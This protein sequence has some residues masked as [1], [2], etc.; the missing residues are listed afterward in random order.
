MADP[1]REIIEL[2]ELRKKIHAIMREDAVVHHY[3]A[4]IHGVRGYRVICATDEETRR[5]FKIPSGQPAADVVVEVS[6]QRAIVAEVKGS[7]LEHALT[8]V[9]NTANHVRGRYALIECKIFLNRQP[10]GGSREFIY[11]LYEVMRV[12]NRAFPA[13]WLLIEHKD[14]GDAG[15]FVRIDGQV[16]NVIFGPLIPR[17]A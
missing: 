14:P 12:Y 16:V 5:E 10:P 7:N 8:Q 13:E 3:Q 17:P 11:A 9:R 15:Q 4:Q 2:E 1:Y 6:P